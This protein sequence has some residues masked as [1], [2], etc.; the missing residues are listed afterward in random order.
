V[1][2]GFFERLRADR[3]ARSSQNLKRDCESCRRLFLLAWPRS[4]ST[5]RRCRAPPAR[6][7]RSRAAAAELVAREE[8]MGAP[9]SS[10]NRPMSG[11]RHIAT[12]RLDLADVKATKTRLGG[13][14]NDV[15]LALCAG[16]LGH[17]LLARGDALPEGNLRAQV[18]VNIRSK[19]RE[20][21]LGNGL[22]SL[23]V[24]LPVSEADP[25]ARYRRVVDCA[26][27]LKAGSQ[28]AGGKTIIDL[29]DI[30]P[31]LAG[32]LLARS[33]FGGAR[34]FN[35]TITNVPGSPQ[36]VVRRRRSTRRGSPART[37]VRR[38]HDRHRGHHV[39]WPDGL[40]PQRRSHCSA[41]RRGARGGHQALVLGAPP[42]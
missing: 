31:P 41:R 19:D 14:V 4:T 23:F 38:T 3:E 30:G 5:R 9:H 10:L 32:A 17:L 42:A 20:H 33:M 16:G 7:I 29:A 8:L 24:E 15:V 1:V 28:R 36:R 11:T 18:P 22:T 35:L 40:W 12:V 6:I 34:M 21:A 27:Q 26:E 25:I 39:R 2:G 13:T 37:A